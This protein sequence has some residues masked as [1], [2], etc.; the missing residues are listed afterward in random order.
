MK[1]QIRQAVFQ[2]LSCNKDEEAF[3]LL[4][5]VFTALVHHC[6]GPEQFSPVSDTIVKQYAET[7]MGADEEQK[8]RI[9]EVVSVVCSVRQ[10]SRMTR[11]SSLLF[12]FVLA[13]LL[14]RQATQ[15]ASRRVREAPALGRVA[16]LPT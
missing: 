2:G 5:R 4:R 6:K 15:R 3:T 8:R 11:T 16:P 12:I 7:V 9:L 1:S 10:G 13:N 14:C